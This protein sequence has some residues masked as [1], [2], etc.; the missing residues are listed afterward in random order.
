MVLGLAL[1]HH[2][3]I[4]NRLTFE[5][6]SILFASFSSEYVIVEF[7]PINDNKVQILIKDKSINLIEYNEDYFTK[8]LS[9]FFIIKEIIRLKDT[10]R[11]LLLLEKKK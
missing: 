3:H 11:S 9:S 1:V 8:A 10:W 2:L 7:I 6:I 4:S 5:Q